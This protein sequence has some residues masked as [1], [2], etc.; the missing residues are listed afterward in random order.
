M[1][2]QKD[3][4]LAKLDEIEHR[5]SEIEKQIAD[6]EV[7]SDPARLIPLTKEQGKLKS[8]VAKYTQPKIYASAC[9]PRQTRFKNPPF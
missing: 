2:E 3:S 4:I 8:M 9:L 1:I 7:S 5:Y 6:P